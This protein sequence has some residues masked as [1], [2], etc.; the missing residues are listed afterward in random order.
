MTEFSFHLKRCSCLNKTSVVAVHRVWMHMKHLD[1]KRWIITLSVKTEQNK[2]HKHTDCQL[3]AGH[4][5]VL[6]IDW[7]LLLRKEMNTT[8]HRRI[9][10]VNS[11]ESFESLDFLDSILNRWGGIKADAVG[12][13]LLQ[14]YNCKIVETWIMVKLQFA[15][16]MI[17]LIFY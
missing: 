9:G 12:D 11:S 16:G 15:C 10:E 13:L 1:H 14:Q 6:T 17:F 2:A 7:I 3:T 8:L 5:C 4:D